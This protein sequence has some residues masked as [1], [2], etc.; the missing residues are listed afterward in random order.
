MQEYFVFAVGEKN[1]LN[2][3]KYREELGLVHKELYVGNS[4]CSLVFDN[5]YTGNSGPK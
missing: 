3:Y 5:N 2:H 1:S 4:P